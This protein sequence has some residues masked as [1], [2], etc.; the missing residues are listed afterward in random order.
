VVV[1]TN[2]IIILYFIAGRNISWHIVVYEPRT[3]RWQ[4]FNCDLI[5][6]RSAGQAVTCL[7]QIFVLGGT[8]NRQTLHYSIEELDTQAVQ[9]GFKK[10]MQV[11]RMDFASAVISDSIMIGG[12]Q[13]GDILSSVEFYKP[14]V[15]EWQQGPS[16]ITPRYGHSFLQVV[17]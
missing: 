10:D 15:D 6:V 14:E 2:R 4:P 16:M 13:S 1:P 3:N 12:G 17:L 7:G 5:E 11:A 9:W 8:D